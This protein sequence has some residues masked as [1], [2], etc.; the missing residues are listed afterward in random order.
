MWICRKCLSQVDD[1]LSICWQCGAGKDGTVDPLF[2]DE[3]PRQ[4]AR[5]P[6]QPVA[7]HGC[8]RCG[9][10]AEPGTIYAADGSALRY[11]P[12]PANWWD[13][14]MTGVFGV[15][16][17]VGRRHDG[18]GTHVPCLRCPHCRLIFFRY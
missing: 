3:P 16:E 8:P 11:R 2:E 18:A 5:L 15:G 17:T 1:V 12:G 6:P 14:F 4:G 10:E 13:N 9:A 7:D